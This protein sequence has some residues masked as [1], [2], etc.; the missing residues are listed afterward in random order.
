MNVILSPKTQK[1]LELRMK[2]GDYKSPDEA[3]R[4]ALQSLEGEAIEDLDQATQQA[5][6][7]AEGQIKRGQGIPLDE[8]FSRL[9]QKHRRA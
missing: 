2:E 5:I 7:R 6:E 9:R 1:L 8:A 4:V 3:I